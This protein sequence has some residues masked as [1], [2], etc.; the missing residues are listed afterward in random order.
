MPLKLIP[1]KII[2]F[3]IPLIIG[4][5]IWSVGYA[6]TLQPGSKYKIIRPIYIMATYNSRKDKILSKNTARAY[7]DTEKLATKSYTAFQVEVPRETVMTIT[8]PIPA[9]WYLPF[10]EKRYLVS[11]DPDLS[12]GLDIELAVARGMEGNLDGLNADIFSRY[13]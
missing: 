4:N 8:S 7:L 13:K 1:S 12:Q 5:F 11:L 9:P 6:D 2:S 3:L 10:S